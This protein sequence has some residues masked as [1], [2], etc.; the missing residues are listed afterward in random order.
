M[1]TKWISKELN[2]IKLK[3]LF[4]GILVVDA[5]K[6]EM[7]LLYVGRTPL[8]SILNHI[9]HTI[10]LS[11]LNYEITKVNGSLLVSMVIQLGKADGDLG[12][13]YLT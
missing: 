3:S 4:N 8:I 7:G 1:E 6:R 11:L 10:L 13:Y 2:R 12:N 5:C 9:F